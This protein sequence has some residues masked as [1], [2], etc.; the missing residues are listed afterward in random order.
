MKIVYDPEKDILQ[1]SFTEV[2]VEE[3]T[4]I[5]PGLVLDYDENGAVIGLELRKASKKMSNPYS[6][7]YSV[8]PADENKHQPK[9]TD[10]D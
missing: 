6:F 2:L 4:Q 1:I 9:V 7:A 5:A 3:T 10:S 8:G